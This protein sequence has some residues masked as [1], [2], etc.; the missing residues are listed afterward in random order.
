MHT[1][2]FNLLRYIN[3]IFYKDRAFLIFPSLKH[4]NL[5]NNQNNMIIKHVCLREIISSVMQEIKCAK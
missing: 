3:S 2:S 5:N 4:F 1:V